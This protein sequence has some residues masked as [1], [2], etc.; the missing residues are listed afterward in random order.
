LFDQIKVTGAM[1]QSKKSP[2][3]PNLLNRIKSDW[4][5]APVKKIFTNAKFAQSDKK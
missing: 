4:R 5:I 1:R 3:T 2:P